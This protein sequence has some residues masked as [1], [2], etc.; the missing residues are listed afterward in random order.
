MGDIR[1][2]ESSTTSKKRLL[3]GKKTTTVSDRLQ[4]KGPQKSTSAYR[5]RPSLTG[6]ATTI[7]KTNRKGEVVREKK[8]FAP[9]GGPTTVVKTNRKGKEKVN[10]EKIKKRDI[11]Y[12]TKGEPKVKNRHTKQK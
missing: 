9:N 10:T 4:T 3:G 1:W 6:T 8:I 11:R 7:T 12:D 5:P 2:E